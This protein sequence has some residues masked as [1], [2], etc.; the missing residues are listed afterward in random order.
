MSPKIVRS[1]LIIA[2]STI[3][4]IQSLSQFQHDVK[5]L[6]VNADAT[7]LN[8]ATL[9]WQY[10]ADGAVRSSPAHSGNMIVFGSS[11]GFVYGISTRGKELWKART[12]GPVS[13]TPFIEQSTVYIVCRKNILYAFSLNNGKLLWK[14]SLGTPLHYEWGFDYYIGSP[15]VEKEKLYV[16]SADGNLY[17]LNTRNGALLWKFNANSLIRSTPAIEGNRIFFGDCSGKVYALNKTN[18]TLQWKFSTIGDTLINESY[19]FDRKAVIASPTVYKEKIF[20]GGRD[21]FLYALDK[22]SGALLWKF[23]YQVSWVIST[24]AIRN[25]VL[26]TGTSDGRFVHALDTENGKELWR[27]M[28]Q[29]T[30]WSS[31][32]ISGN[33]AVVIP[34]NDGYLY[35]LELHTGKELWRYHMGPQ[36]F[37]SPLLLG[38]SV[39]VG[40]DLGKMFA[41]ET[42]QIDKL[43]PHAIKRAVFWMKNPVIQSFQS[44]MDVAV[45]DYFIKEGYE[46]Y[47]E[48]DVKDFLLARI[49]SDTTSVLVFATNYFLPSLTNDTLGSNILQKYLQRGGRVV[50]LGLNPASYELDSAQKQVVAINFE[51]AKR[52]TGIPYRYKDL[53]THGGFYYSTITEEGK[54]WGLTTPFVGITGMPLQDVTLALAIDENGNAPAWIKSFSDKKHSGFVQLYLTPNRLHT[55]PEIQKVVEYGLR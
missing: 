28:T 5:H 26:I 24:V 18:G 14:K 34:S 31:P 7:I 36:I 38:N 11:G 25:N 13:S 37:S 30:V 46:F 45:R 12:E 19:G 29:A 27:F 44:G 17:S 6:G 23:D 50:V 4:T 8:N 43:P 21:G 40:N 39:Y 20:I 22:S 1:I 32:A 54:K 51:Q 48:T 42:Q 49:Q 33:D 16:G 53:R 41:F 47:D 3:F 10:Q 35:A 15:T 9:T 52:I 2:M 55:L